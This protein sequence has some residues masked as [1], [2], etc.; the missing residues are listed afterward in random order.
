[1]MV[2]GTFTGFCPLRFIL[3]RLGVRLGYCFQ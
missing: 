2:Q 3:K 1:M